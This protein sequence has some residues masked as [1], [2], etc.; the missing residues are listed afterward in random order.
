MLIYCILESSSLKLPNIFKERVFQNII[1]N[2]GISIKLGHLDFTYRIFVFF[3]S[4]MS[5]Y[6]VKIHSVKVSFLVKKQYIII[7]FIILFYL[8]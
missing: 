6:N 4:F 8:T 1:N 3:V 7:L 5:L 2:L